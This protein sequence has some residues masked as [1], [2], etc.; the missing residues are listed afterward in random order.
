MDEMKT[1]K[2]RRKEIAKEIV[3]LLAKHE[4][5]VYEATAILELTK[6]A[7]DNHAMVAPID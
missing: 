3:S 2:H 6:N 4:L 1:I 7:V 5:S